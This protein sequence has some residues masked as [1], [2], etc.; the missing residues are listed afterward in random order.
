MN[1]SISNRRKKIVSVLMSILMITIGSVLAAFSLELFLVPN[2]IFDGGVVGVSMIL[3]DF[4]GIKLGILIVALNIP[5]LLYALKMLGPGFIGKAGYGMAMFSVFTSVFEHFHLTPTTDDQLLATVFG[6]ILLGCGVG[7]V[8]R[9]GGCLDGTEIVALVVSK[10]SSF[11]VGN[12]ILIINVVIYL[13][14]GLIYGIDSGLYSMIMYFISSKVIDI[15]EVG[16]EQGKT[17][18]IITEDG[19]KI[20]RAIYEDLGRTVTFIP[21]QG[22]VSGTRKDILYCVITRTEIYSLH[23]LIEKLD[24]EAFITISDV[25]EII[26]NHIKRSEAMVIPEGSSPETEAPKANQ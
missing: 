7:L 16:M 4:L 9:G 11:S 20:A 8:L 3:S 26:G 22:L 19:P 6:G 21:G 15:V 1:A 14:A 12:V 5:F 25:S 24:V 18:T 17:V 13:I 23:Q 10:R 2:T